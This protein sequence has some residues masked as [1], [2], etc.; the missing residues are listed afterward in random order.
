MTP[1]QVLAKLDNY[2][3]LAAEKQQLDR[4]W[5]EYES[6]GEKA[7][8][9]EEFEKRVSRRKGEVEELQNTQATENRQYNIRKDSLVTRLAE[10]RAKLPDPAEVEGLT[11]EISSLETKL[12]ALAQ[13]SGGI[14]EAADPTELR[15]E[16]QR[17]GE[18]R[19]RQRSLKD[20]LSACLSLEEIRSRKSILTDELHEVTEQLSELDTLYLRQGNAAEYARKYRSQ[21]EDVSQQISENLLHIES[22]KEEFESLE[23]DSL[24]EQVNTMPSLETLESDLEN[25]EQK[26]ESVQREIRT[27]QE[28]A[29]SLH[30]EIERIEPDLP[31]QIEAQADGLIRTHIG[32][33]FGT[34]CFADDEWFL[35]TPLEQ[36]RSLRTL[37]RGQA[38][39]VRFII[40]AAILKLLDTIEQDFIIWDDVLGSLDDDQIDNMKSLLASI[41]EK[42]QVILFARNSRLAEEGNVI[43]LK[44]EARVQSTY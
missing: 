32:D 21:L 12:S 23:T 36:K 29:E 44:P 6:G 15:V 42:R 17:F 28:L 11:S 31:G 30:R 33:E 16:W 41:S 40:R 7:E 18:L 19:Q 2:R 14:L 26:L 35:V 9:I 37:S 27:T 10:L 4:E 39:L 43:E 34:V 3:E 13:T 22:V 5:I 25:F 24:Q 8:R 38:D 20:E 1:A